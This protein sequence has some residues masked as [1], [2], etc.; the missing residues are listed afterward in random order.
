VPQDGARLRLTP[1]AT[2]AE[3]EIEALADAISAE[4]AAR[5]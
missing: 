3:A 1:M 4:L 2:H 5:R